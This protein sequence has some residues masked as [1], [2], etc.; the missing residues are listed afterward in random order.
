MPE[1]TDLPAAL[2]EPEL[3]PRLAEAVARAYGTVPAVPASVDAA[4]LADARSGFHRRRRFALA[5][6][7]VGASAAAA[8]AI[9]IV[10]LNLRHDRAAPPAVAGDVDRNGSV[11]ILD[12]FALAKKIQGPRGAVAPW[13]DVNR[14]G[15]LDQR[16][17][18]QVAQ[19]AVRLR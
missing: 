9:V 18:D 2:A 13:E 4:I 17:V 5:G 14:D 6:R 15:V 16:D 8:A 7:W 10:A 1:P 11:N 12:A 3:P 19:Q